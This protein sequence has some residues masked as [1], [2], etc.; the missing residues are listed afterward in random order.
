MVGKSWDSEVVEEDGLPVALSVW[1][2]RLV[3]GNA[4]VVVLEGMGGSGVVELFPVNTGSLI[5]S[6]DE[7]KPVLDVDDSEEWNSVV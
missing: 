5:P 3:V 7:L 6:S 4:R 2:A 1:G